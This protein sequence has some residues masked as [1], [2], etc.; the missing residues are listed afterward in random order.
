M[1]SYLHESKSR[2]DRYEASGRRGI[3]FSCHG[4][5]LR[6][7]FDRGSGGL[8]GRETRVG[9]YRLFVAHIA[10]GYARLIEVSCDGDDD[11]MQTAGR[12][13]T[14]TAVDAWDGKRFVGRMEPLGGMRLNAS[15]DGLDQ[16]Q[17][18]ACDDHASPNEK[19]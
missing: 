10:G 14:S 6:T 17:A 3:A 1:P 16:T 13:A 5:L 9:Q 11:A 18:H 4:R 2:E 19:G 7:K 8:V 12:L 15:F